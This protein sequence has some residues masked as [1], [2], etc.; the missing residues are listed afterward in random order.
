MLLQRYR[1]LFESHV[2]EIGRADKFRLYQHRPHMAVTKRLNPGQRVDD[3]YFHPFSG[4]KRDQRNKVKRVAR[5]R[6]RHP[7]STQKPRAGQIAPYPDDPDPVIVLVEIERTC[8]H[9]DPERPAL[10]CIDGAVDGKLL[11]DID[12]GAN[13]CD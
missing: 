10:V 6:G 5:R 12:L 7:R 13:T 8:R 9:N 4:R 2:A 1:T 11:E 3:R